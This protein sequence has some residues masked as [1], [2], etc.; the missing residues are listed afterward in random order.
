MCVS[1]CACVCARSLQNDGGITHTNRTDKT[2]IT[3]QWTAPTVGSG[4]IEI[5]WAVLQAATTHWAN[6]EGAILA[7][8]CCTYVHCVM[9]SCVCVCVVA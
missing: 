6:Q 9:Y 7:G 1:M 2:M 8:V 3:A 5:R 4:N